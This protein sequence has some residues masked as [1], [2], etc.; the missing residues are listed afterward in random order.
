[1]KG[2]KA[3]ARGMG[4]SG[5]PTSAVAPQEQSNTFNTKSLTFFRHGSDNH[6]HGAFKFMALAKPEMGN[7][8]RGEGS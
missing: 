6:P 8:S 5:N 7:M 2:L 4:I 3:I 1:M